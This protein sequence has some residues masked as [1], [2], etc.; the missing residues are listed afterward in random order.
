MRRQEKWWTIIGPILEGTLFQ[1]VG[2]ECVGGGKHTVVR[3]YIDKP[4]GI[5]IDDIVYVIDSG[6][7]KQTQFDPSK[8]MASLE[9]W[10]NY[11]FSKE[12]FD[13]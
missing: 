13:A 8:G 6:K 2:V 7:M 9:E 11:C 10:Y 5:T 1:L 12:F 4:G 3:V